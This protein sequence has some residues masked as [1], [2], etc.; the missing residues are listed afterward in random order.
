MSPAATSFTAS[1]CDV[2]AADGTP[3]SN[4]GPRLEM[5]TS[6]GTEAFAGR[7]ERELSGH[8]RARP[9]TQRRDPG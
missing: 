5:F 8:R 7:A 6:M 4:C 2:S 3:A 9:Q 1:G